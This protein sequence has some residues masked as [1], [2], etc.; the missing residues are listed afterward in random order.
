MSPAFSQRHRLMTAGPLDQLAERAHVVRCR[1]A[2][3]SAG[4]ELV[5]PR[6]DVSGESCRRPLQEAEVEVVLRTR[7][8]EL[9]LVEGGLVAE[10]LVA[11]GHR[12]LLD[13][14]VDAGEHAVRRRLPLTEPNERLHLPREPPLARQHGHLATEVLR[15]PAQHVAEQDRSFVVEVVAGGHHV[16]AVLTRRGVEQMTLREPARRAR[17]APSGLGGSGYVEPE[18]VADVAVMEGEPALLGKGARV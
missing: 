6:L 15:L 13:D 4:G 18:F 2:A 5:V 10:V 17:Y 7:R 11:L 9:D 14:V 8:L 12:A 1:R 3:P 16:V